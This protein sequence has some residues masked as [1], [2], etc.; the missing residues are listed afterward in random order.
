[1]RTIHRGRNRNSYLNDD[2]NEGY[3]ME[4]VVEPIR[5]NPVI[6]YQPIRVV[7]E[8]FCNLGSIISKIS[9]VIIILGVCFLFSYL[10]LTQN[11]KMGSYLWNLTVNDNE[12]FNNNS[13]DNVNEGLNLTVGN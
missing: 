10:H 9:F 6:F 1:M 5:Y 4:M 3:A 11:I 8:P 12:V 7:E 2:E 13:I